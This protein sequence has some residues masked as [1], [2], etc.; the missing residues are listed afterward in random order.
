MLERNECTYVILMS[1]QLLLPVHQL[2]I[3]ADKLKNN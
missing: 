2:E 3:F 1:T